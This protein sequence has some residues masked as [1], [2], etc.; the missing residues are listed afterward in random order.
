[1]EN[2]AMELWQVSI[3][4]INVLLVILG[5]VAMVAFRHLMKVLGEIKLDIKCSNRRIRSLEI[6]AAKIETKLGIPNHTKHS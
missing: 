3:W 4:V 1:M 6:G 5:T 2:Q